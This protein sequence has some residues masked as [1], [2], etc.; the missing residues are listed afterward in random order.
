MKKIFQNNPD[1]DYFFSTIENNIEYNNDNY[2]EKII[3]DGRAAI[4]VNNI[5]HLI[6]SKRLYYKKDSKISL[7]SILGTINKSLFE[8]NHCSNNNIALI[9]LYCFTFINRKDKSVDKINELLNYRMTSDL[10]QYVVFSVENEL[11]YN[12]TFGEFRFGTLDFYKFNRKCD[13]FHT[14]YAKLY[15]NDFLDKLSIER[16][17]ITVPIIDLFKIINNSNYGNDRL[18]EAF[19][20]YYEELSH[21]YFKNFDFQFE[22]QQNLMTFINDDYFNLNQWKIIG[23]P[24]FISIFL[25]PSNIIK[26][27]IISNRIASININFAESDKRNDTLKDQLSKEYNFSNFLDLELHHTIENYLSFCSKAKRYKKDNLFNDSFLHYVIALDLLFGEKNSTTKSVANRTSICTY[28]IFDKSFSENTKTMK[29]IYD[30]R[31]SYV[32][33]GKSIKIE[34]LEVV[35]EICKEILLVLFRLNQKQSEW[36]IVDW[37]R[38]IDFLIAHLDAGEAVS[39][40]QYLELGIK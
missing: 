3:S 14:N 30:E 35:E 4:D 33:A 18:N 21:Y 8:F 38:K 19:Y 26:G 15:G 28:R 13:K 24:T 22:E 16:K 7:N 36:K 29:Y 39:D 11:N 5:N 17:Y 1:F 27:W 6:D 23:K 32:H 2:E 12:L 31:S 40:G 25:I 34:S 37:L 20:T 10:S 9:I